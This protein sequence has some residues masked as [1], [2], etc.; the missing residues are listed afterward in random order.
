MYRTA[1][2]FAKN[3]G[4]PDA[5]I[6]KFYCILFPERNRRAQGRP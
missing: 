6:V 1:L 2:Q 3:A 5:V 4:L